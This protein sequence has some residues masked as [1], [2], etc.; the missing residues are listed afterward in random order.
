MSTDHAP[1]KAYTV[2]GQKHITIQAADGRWVDG[3]RI[4]FTTA[5]GVHTHVDVPLATYTRPNVE[6]LLAERADTIDAISK[7]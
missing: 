3:M 6:R 1:E 7:L 4:E 5:S 2:T